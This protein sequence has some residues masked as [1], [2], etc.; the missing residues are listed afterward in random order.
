LIEAPI[1]SI[2]EEHLQQLLGRPE[3]RRLDFKADLPDPK[4][5]KECNGMIADIVA[6]ANSEGG[7]IVYG[8]EE[9]DGVAARI[10]PVTR[11]LSLDKA[12]QRIYSWA[13]DN[14]DVRLPA[15]HVHA[16]PLAPKP[17]EAEDKAPGEAMVIRVRRAFWP[18][19]GAR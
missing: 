9:E 14:I 3:N 18:H 6:F 1:D 16:V 4:D 19:T 5:K 12:I 8:I 2:T 15:F 17:G 7:D 10:R 13:Q 11:T